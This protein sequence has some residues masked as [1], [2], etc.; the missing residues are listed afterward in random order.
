VVVVVAVMV[1]CCGDERAHP[2]VAEFG[3]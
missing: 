2:Q 1:R 3:L